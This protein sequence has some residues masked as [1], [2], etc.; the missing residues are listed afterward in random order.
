[1]SE[2]DDCIFCRIA[3]GKAPAYVVHQDDRTMAFMDIN[4]AARGHTLVI[5]K[6]H[7]QNI[8]EIPADDLTAVIKT[9]QKVARAV[10]AVLVPQG[11][12]L[13]QS[14][15]PGA[16]QSVPHFHIH[17]LPRSLYDDLPLN[18]RLSPGDRRDIETLA[19]EIRAELA[20]QG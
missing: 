12:N 10:N 4:P 11:M 5:A 3:A 6:N 9:A 7:A 14:N 17:V 20:K 19:G 18:W 15:G 8:F 1:M 2:H 13:L 16:A